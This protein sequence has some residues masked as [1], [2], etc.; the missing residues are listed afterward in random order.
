MFL[1]IAQETMGAFE[2]IYT[3]A[4]AAWYSVT[5]IPRGDAI[6]EASKTR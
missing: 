2:R 5:A 1:P 4:G 6:R 3:G